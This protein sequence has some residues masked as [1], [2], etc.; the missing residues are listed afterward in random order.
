MSDYNNYVQAIN[1]IYECL[2]KMKS[3]W[4]DQDN[5]NYIESIEVYKDTVIKNA[6][7]FDSTS[8]SITP[9]NDVQMEE[10]GQ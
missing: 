6:N 10:L 4:N 1:K 8:S 9:K 5:Y 3:K 7:A 2:A